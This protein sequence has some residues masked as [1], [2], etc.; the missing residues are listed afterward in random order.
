MATRAD[1]A[2]VLCAPSEWS[3]A[4]VAYR[5][6]RRLSAALYLAP[7]RSSEAKDFGLIATVVPRSFTAKEPTVAR[8]L[9]TWG[10]LFLLIFT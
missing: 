9:A 2:L 1:R 4:G 7:K 10:F 8:R 3:L 6:A 5:L